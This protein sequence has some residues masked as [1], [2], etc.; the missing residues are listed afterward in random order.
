[1]QKILDEKN[2]K[3]TPFENNVPEIEEEIPSYTRV[4]SRNPTPSFIPSLLTQRK[5]KS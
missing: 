3:E 4:L 5:K 1:L 2:A